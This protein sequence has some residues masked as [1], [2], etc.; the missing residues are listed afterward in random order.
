[1]TDNEYEIYF[2]ELEKNAFS[3]GKNKPGNEA[4]ELSDNK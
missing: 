1:M 3:F 2:N 4:K